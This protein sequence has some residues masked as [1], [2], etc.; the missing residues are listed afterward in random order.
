MIAPLNK[1]E[2][3]PFF[4]GMKPGFVA[5]AGQGSAHVEF[6]SGDLIF[7][8]GEPANRFYLIFR[9]SLILEAHDALCGTVDIEQIG[10]GDVLGWSWLY[11]P[12]VWH[13][14]ARV[15]EPVE[16][17]ALDGGHLLTTS[18]QEH[19]FGFEL[20]KRISKIVIHRLQIARKRLLSLSMQTR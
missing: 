17:I 9:G 5:L 19:E 1:V 18:E 20:H 7:Q 14:R 13:F 8:E 11:A 6:G 10:G 15:T 4:E 3:H 2:D 12:F 16:A